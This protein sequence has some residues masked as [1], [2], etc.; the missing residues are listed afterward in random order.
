MVNAILVMHSNLDCITGIAL[1]IT[2]FYK[3]MHTSAFGAK[4]KNYE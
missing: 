2:H 3:I 1:I 4:F